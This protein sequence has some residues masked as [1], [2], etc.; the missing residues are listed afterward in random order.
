[1]SRGVIDQAFSRLYQTKLHSLNSQ[2]NP[3]IVSVGGQ[4]GAGKSRT[5]TRMKREYQSRVPLFEINGDSLRMFHPDY[6]WLINDP[7]PEV[8]PR[9]TAELSAALVERSL[10]WACAHRVSV[11]VEG[12][13]RRPEVTVGTLSTFASHG[14]ST[15]LV[16]LAVPKAFSWQGCVMRYIGAL[17]EKKPARWAPLEAHDAAWR[18]IPLTISEAIVSG[19]IDRLT[20][21]LRSGRVL[22]DAYSGEEPFSKEEVLAALEVGQK[23]GTASEMAVWRA[24]QRR[25]QA[26][27]PLLNENIRQEASFV[28]EVPEVRQW[29]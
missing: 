4:P 26:V 12:T 7:D 20:V 5:L 21:I 13:M 6:H 25:I 11:I 24:N 15:H 29:R 8:Y 27:A 3:V 2:D 1:M 17:H 16:V 14:F 22:Y 28:F 10:D 23:Y 18:G 19:E 9:E